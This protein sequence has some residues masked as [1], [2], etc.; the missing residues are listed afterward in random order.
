MDEDSQYKVVAYKL[1]DKGPQLD[2]VPTGK[3]IITFS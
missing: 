1:V 3:S 2:L